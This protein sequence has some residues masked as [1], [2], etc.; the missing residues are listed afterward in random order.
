MAC[1]GVGSLHSSALMVLLI[2]S[3]KNITKY[4]Y[5]FDNYK[6][7]SFKQPLLLTNSL[8]KLQAYHVELNAIH[9]RPQG[10]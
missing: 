7:P 4:I 1:V 8:Y 10:D 2:G 5:I 3:S 9:G 6:S